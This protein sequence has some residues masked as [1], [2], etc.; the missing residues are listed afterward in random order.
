MCDTDSVCNTGRSNKTDGLPSP[1]PPILA[2][3]TLVFRP[4]K[5]FVLFIYKVIH[6]SIE[7]IRQLHEAMLFLDDNCCDNYYKMAR[8]KPII[9]TMFK[10]PTQ[11]DIRGWL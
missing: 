11:K 10:T 7:T 5:A 4:R 6:N 3:D 2:L 9:Y 8:Q 1:T